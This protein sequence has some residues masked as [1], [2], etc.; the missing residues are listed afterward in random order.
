MSAPR[1]IK[2]YANRRLYDATQARYVSLPEIRQMA[3]AGIDF[4][5]I[6]KMTGEDITPATLLQVI[7]TQEL[8]GTR[9]L[10]REFLLQVIR[11][12]EHGARTVTASYLEQSLKS[13]ERDGLREDHADRGDVHD[14]EAARRLAQNHFQRWQAVARDIYQKLTN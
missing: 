13:F 12:Q 14:V 1:T 9:L 7:A 2:K 11:S 4:V 5:V 10:T 6:D 3:T 8:E